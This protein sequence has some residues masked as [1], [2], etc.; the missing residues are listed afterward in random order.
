MDLDAGHRA[1]QRRGAVVEQAHG[2]GADEHD[3][4][5][6]PVGWDRAVEE[7]LGRDVEARIVRAEAHPDLPARIGRHGQL[8]QADRDDAGVV[9]PDQE[10]VRPGRHPQDVERECRH[11]GAARPQHHRHPP[12]HAVALGADGEDAPPRGGPLQHRQIADQAGEADQRPVR[13]ELRAH[14]GGAGLRRRPLPGP[15]DGG[16]RGGLAQ[17][18]RHPPDRLGEDPVAVGLR[19]QVGAGRLAQVGQGLGQERRRQAVGLGEDDVEG[20]DRRPGLL[21]LPAD[22]GEPGAGPGPLAEFLQAR[23]VDID[24]RH[25][26]LGRRHP[27]REHLERVEGAHPQG[28]DRRRIGDPHEQQQHEQAAGQ[29]AAR[30]DAAAEAADQTENSSAPRHGGCPHAWPPPRILAPKNRQNA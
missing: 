28:L 14:H 20:D 29:Q 13:V 24:D 6:Q 1:V 16:A 23:L 11:H 25:R 4:F 9:G 30:S 27:G 3:L 22:R 10:G 18:H 26:A 12:H 2:R 15:G 7:I 17:H 19:P 21:Q 8:G 5:A